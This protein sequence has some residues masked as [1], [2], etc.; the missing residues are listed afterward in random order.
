MTKSEREL[1]KLEVAQ[2][3][4]IRR[5]DKEKR[6]AKKAEKAKAWIAQKEVWAQNKLN[7][8]AAK[9]EADDIK[10]ED[11]KIITQMQHEKI[12]I[13]LNSSID[14]IRDNIAKGR[15]IKQILSGIFYDIRHYP[16]DI[17]DT[18]EYSINSILNIPIP[19]GAKTADHFGGR[20][21]IGVNGA[22]LVYTKKINT[23]E[24]MQKYL[25]KFACTLMTTASFNQRIKKFQNAGTSITPEIY[26]QEYETEFNYKFTSEQRML[27]AD[28]FVVTKLQAGPRKHS[29]S[30]RK[31]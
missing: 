15:T 11:K 4:E 19:H 12:L 2:R 28:R 7:K 16:Y 6:D 1:H 18:K 3:K 14:Q 25:L 5:I 30:S 22:Y 23:Y 10:V 27:F 31:P 21:D 29:R 17:S 24:D 9:K 8:A 13:N 20:T 26:M